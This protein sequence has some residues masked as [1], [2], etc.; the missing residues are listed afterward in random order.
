MTH[1]TKG[2]QPISL[3]IVRPNHPKNE[4]IGNEFEGLNLRKSMAKKEAKEED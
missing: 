2:N 4:D 3:R 1:S